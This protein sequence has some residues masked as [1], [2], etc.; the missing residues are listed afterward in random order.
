MI[1][2]GAVIAGGAKLSRFSFQSLFKLVTNKRG[3]GVFVIM[4]NFAKGVISKFGEA[5]AEKTPWPV[6]QE[7]GMRILANDRIMIDS[8]NKLV[9]FQGKEIAKLTVA[10]A[11]FDLYT[12]FF[13]FWVIFGLLLWFNR[14]CFLGTDTP[15]LNAVLLTIFIMVLLEAV[16]LLLVIV[17][18]D[19]PK[20][21]FTVP[22]AGVIA[23]FSNMDVVLP[24]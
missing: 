14:L 8:I 16:T 18:G 3:F 9:S 20:E 4:L 19:M 22:F 24:F 17:F 7:A 21:S 11:Y 15:M 5:W 12:A 10:N 1:A 2:K 13:A 6:V 23:F